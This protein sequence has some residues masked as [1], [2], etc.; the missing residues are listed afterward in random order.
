M[1]RRYISFSISCFVFFIRRG[2]KEM[3]NYPAKTYTY[4]IYTI[5]L[6]HQ[7]KTHYGYGNNEIH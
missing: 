4:D 6:Q 3:L 1:K 5:Y 7:N 2:E